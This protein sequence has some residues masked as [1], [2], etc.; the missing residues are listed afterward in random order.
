MIKNLVIKNL[1]KM[2]SFSPHW[3]LEKSLLKTKN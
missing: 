1:K 3:L 2:F